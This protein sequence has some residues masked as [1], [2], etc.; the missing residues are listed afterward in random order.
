MFSEKNPELEVALAA[1]CQ[2]SAACRV[3]QNKISADG[4][5]KEDRSPVTVADFASQALVCRK[6]RAAYPEDPV[7][8]EEGADG[9]RASGGAAS[10]GS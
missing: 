5:R 6:L 7:V 1:V 4:L 9:L 2:A 3:V 10:G 8:G